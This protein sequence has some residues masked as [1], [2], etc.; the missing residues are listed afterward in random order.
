MRFP[1]MRKAAPVRKPTEA[2]TQPHVLYL[3]S[4]IGVMVIQWNDYIAVEEGLRH[5]I[6]G[7]A[8]NKIAGSVQQVPWIVQKDPKA[9]RSEQSNNAT[10]ISDL[11][12]VLDSPNDD[13]T[14]AQLRYWLTLN[15]CG[16]GRAPIKVGYSAVRT[17]TP[18]GIYPLE[19]RMVTAKQNARGMVEN[20]QYGLGP[21]APT[22]PSLATFKKNPTASGFVSQIWKIGLKGYQDPKDVTTPMKSIGLPA[23]V[24]KS[25]LTRAIQTAEGHPNVRYLVTCSKTLTQ[26]Q[27]DTL[28]QHLN[29]DHGIEGFD[30]GSVPVLQNAGDIEIHTIDNDLSDIHSKMPSDDMARLIYGAFDIPIALAGIGAADAA[31]FAGNYD[32]SRA[33]FWEDTIIPMYV[34]PIFK[35]LTNMLCPPGVII[36][37]DLE[38][39]PALV[40]KRVATMKEVQ[41]VS[42]LTT[43]EKR[44]LFNL[45]A[46]S[47]LPEVMPATPEAAGS[48]GET[49]DE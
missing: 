48:I 13:M 6:V 46:S 18:N 29:S 15:Y 42:F 40:A 22:Y 3:N 25:L 24:I 30:A 34:N 44:A 43:T 7:K 10:F 37:P 28:K 14:A 35:G 36:V 19:T 47:A 38:Q 23:Q 2:P 33:S 12:A 16:Y 41:G 27:L 11:Q 4:G 17:A 39:I 9:T 49:N 21:D 26:D 1:F 5:P 8:L 45:E 32:G 20:F 31:K